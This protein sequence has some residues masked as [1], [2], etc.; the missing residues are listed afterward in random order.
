[1]KMS[2]INPCGYERQDIGC[3]QYWFLQTLTHI[4]LETTGYYPKIQVSYEYIIN[5]ERAFSKRIPFQE[6]VLP[7]VHRTRLPNEIIFE[8]DGEKREDNIKYLESIYQVLKKKKGFLWITDHFGR[9]PHLH[10]LAKDERTFTRVLNY[11]LSL[12]ID[13]LV[14]TGKHLIRMEGGI[15]EKNSPPTFSSY[16]KSFN[17]IKRIERPEDVVFPELLQKKP[18]FCD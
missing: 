3:R 10:F 4:G 2:K 1:V 6:T 8:V 18:Q 16:F 5:G 12:K 13:H 7:C 11:S 14:N 15:Y 17:S 9:S